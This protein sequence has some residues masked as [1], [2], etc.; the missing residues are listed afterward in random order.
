MH[1]G[2]GSDPHAKLPPAHGDT[3]IQASIGDI[4]AL[5]PNITT[6]QASH[7]VGALIYD[8]LVGKGKNVEDVPAMASSWQVSKDCLTLT[9]NLRKDVKWHDGRPFTAEDVLFTHHLTMHPK[10]P[11][12]Y[13]DE[14]ELVERVEAPDPYTVRVTYKKP[15][16]KAVESWGM[17]MLPKHRLAEFVES[18]KLRESPQNQQPIGT[19]PYLFKE[20]KPAE[21][22]VVVA[23][24]DYYAGRPYVGRWVYRIIPS[25]ATIFLE[26]KAQGVD[27]ASLTVI[28]YMRQTEYPAFNKAYNKLRYQGRSY[29]FLAFNLKDPRFADLRVR[30]AI[31][32]AI[33]K[34]EIIDGVTLGVAKEVSGPIR[35][36]TW[37]YTDNVKKYEHDP[38][39]AKKL[40]TEAGWVDRDGDGVVEDKTGRPFTFTI[41]TNQGN[42]ERKR[43]A[44]LIQQRLKEVGIKV[45]LHIVEWAAFINKFVKPR[46]F[47]VMM[48]GLGGATDPDQYVVFHSSQT[49]HDQMNRTGYS[50]PEIDRLLELGRA[51][52]HQEPRRPHYLRM[53]EILAEDIPMIFL[54]SRDALPVVA[55]RVRGIDPGPAGILYNRPQWYVPKALQR[56]TAD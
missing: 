12:P 28:Q 49:G 54:Y 10:T 23:N 56:Y 13:K 31:A 51:T 32:H 53:Q 52:C 37:A 3:L 1:G 47:E 19:G 20:W 26:L 15:Y 14:F 36:G 39:K 25:Q 24:K 41:R 18:G 6:D 38:T 46:N 7:E 50:N 30:Q 29:E 35:P 21:K 5:I 45:E 44:E 42:D 40:L 17:A 11:A 27:L 9:F 55:T 4:G 8:G 43:A 34:K 2:G 16:A 48:L 33:S 22:V